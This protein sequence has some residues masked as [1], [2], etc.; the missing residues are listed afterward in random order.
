VIKVVDVA[1]HGD[2][3]SESAAD[4]LVDSLDPERAVEII[5]NV[6][7]N[8]LRF[9]VDTVGKTTAELC[10]RVLLSNSCVL[11]S[12]LVALSGMP[13]ERL[14]GVVYHNVP[15]KVHHEVKEAGEA[16]MSWLERLLREELITPPQ[17]VIAPGGLEGINDALDRMK[18][19][20]ISGKRLI[21]QL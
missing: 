6:T 16:M 4:L 10:Q 19:G 21:V 13:N 20:E 15:M 7:K 18:R 8:Q 2:Q 1:K 3:L 11:R 9:A 17:A 5:R 14:D 12:H